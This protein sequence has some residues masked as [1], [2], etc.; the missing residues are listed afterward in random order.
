MSLAISESFCQTN[1][2]VNGYLLV[3]SPDLDLKGWCFVEG[4]F[5]MY[6][7]SKTILPL[8]VIAAKIPPRVDGTQHWMSCSDMLKKYGDAKTIM[9]LMAQSIFGTIDEVILTCG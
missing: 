3:F 7:I 8:N 9:I 6:T 2:G 1:F 5:T 4:D